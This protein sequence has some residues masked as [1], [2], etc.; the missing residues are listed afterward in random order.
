MCI[1]KKHTLAWKV[2]MSPMFIS[3]SMPT[4]MGWSA[5]MGSKV[6]QVME[7][8][9]MSICSTEPS[10]FIVVSNAGSGELKF[11]TCSDM[12]SIISTA[13]WAYTSIMLDLRTL[14]PQSLPP[15]KTLSSFAGGMCREAIDLIGTGV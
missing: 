14:M 15:T 8:S 9:L 7:L 2:L 5:A 6:A 4:G 12:Q 11:H 10:V 13:R 3:V 1:Q